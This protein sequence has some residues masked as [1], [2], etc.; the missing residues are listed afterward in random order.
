MADPEEVEE[1]L[2]TMRES[3]RR[4]VATLKARH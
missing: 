4:G 2:T 3:L 1:L